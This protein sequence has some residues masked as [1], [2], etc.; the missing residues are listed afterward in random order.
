MSEGMNKVILLG[1]LGAEPELR[2]TTS[3]VAVLSFRLAT[4]E[5]W[6]DKDRKKQERTEWH[7]V[8]VWGARAESLS[9]M[10]HKGTSLLVEGGIRTS[11]YDKDGQRRYKT[12]VHAKDVVF[13]GRRATAHGSDATGMISPE[14]ARAEQATLTSMVPPQ[15][16][17]AP[18]QL[19]E[20]PF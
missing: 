17:P 11:S 10:L 2:Y 7:T 16:G 12:E 6:L 8:V 15:P 1:N 18:D 19:D 3:G 14:A 9:R 13:A 5:T 4:T 20:L